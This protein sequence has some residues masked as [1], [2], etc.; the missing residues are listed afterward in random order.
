MLS[1]SGGGEAIREGGGRGGAL[2]GDF[3]RGDLR[4]LEGVVDNSVTILGWG[5][6]VISL[7]SYPFFLSFSLSSFLFFD[8]G[9]GAKKVKSKDSTEPWALECARLDNT[10]Q[11]IFRYELHDSTYSEYYF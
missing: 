7:S 6:G 3:L 4:G 9:R 2:E 1:K 5:E 11:S 10:F 8:G